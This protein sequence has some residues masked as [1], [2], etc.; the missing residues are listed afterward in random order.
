MI[1]PDRRRFPS[2]RFVCLL[3]AS[4]LSIGSFASPSSQPKNLKPYALIFGTAWGPDARP[5]YGVRVKVRRESGKHTHWELMSD[6]LGEFA[7]RVPAGKADYVIWCDTYKSDDGRKLQAD[8][9]KV[10][11]ENDERVDTGLHLK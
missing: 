6:H 4:I 10:H 11:V 2:F 3:A 1:T 7:Q 8:P 9:V 5:L